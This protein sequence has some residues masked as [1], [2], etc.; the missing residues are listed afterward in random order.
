MNVYVLP[1]F[2]RLIF[3]FYFTG[4]TRDN[5]V[6]YSLIDAVNYNGLLYFLLANVL[7]GVIN[8]SVKTILIPPLQSVLIIVMYMLILSIITFVLYIYKWKIKFW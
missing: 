1:L 2:Q 7:T 6:S 8:L 4:K 5:Y 3:F